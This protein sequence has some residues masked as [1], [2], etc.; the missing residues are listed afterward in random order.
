MPVV[1]FTYSIGANNL[2]SFSSSAYDTDGSISS[3]RWTFGDGQ[4]SGGSSAN[5]QYVLAG[6]YNVILSVTDNYGGVGTATKQIIISGSSTTSNI[7]PVSQFTFS[8]NNYNV[9]F[10]SSSYDSDGSISNYL[11]DFGDGQTSTQIGPLTHQYILTGNYNV[12]LTVVDNNGA[13][14]S[15]SQTV[16]IGGSSTSNVPP[17]AA[18]TFWT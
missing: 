5:H 11:W 8:V 13:S 10:T 17:I 9:L 4:T 16:S 7:A 12:K 18:F 3:Y 15:S 2:V 14:A 1:D 6:T